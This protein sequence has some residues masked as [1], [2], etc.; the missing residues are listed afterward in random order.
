M[1]EAT[2]PAALPADV[3]SFERVTTDA[4]SYLL[5]SEQE[6]KETYRLTIAGDKAGGCRWSDDLTGEV[7]GTIEGSDGGTCTAVVSPGGTRVGLGV[8]DGSGGV[9]DGT[10]IGAW[11]DI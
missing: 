4:P 8:V 10:K 9:V 7:Y 11:R 6:L 2:N 3:V 5:L 1:H